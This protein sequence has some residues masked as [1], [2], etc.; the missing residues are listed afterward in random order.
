MA[1]HYKIHD[2]VE[3]PD[4][5]RQGVVVYVYQQ[6]PDL[7]AVRFDDADVPLAVHIEDVRASAAVRLVGG[8]DDR[9]AHRLRSHRNRI[10]IGVGD[11]RHRHRRGC[12]PR[13]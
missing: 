3:D 4:S 1:H 6:P 9:V 12:D 2:R 10:A 13:Q 11:W 5:H 7:L 8:A